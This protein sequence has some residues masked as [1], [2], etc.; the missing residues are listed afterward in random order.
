MKKCGCSST[1]WLHFK[2][3]WQLIMWLWLK[4]SNCSPQGF[5]GFKKNSKYLRFP[6]YRFSRTGVTHL[7]TH[8]HTYILTLPAATGGTDWGKSSPLSHLI[9]RPDNASLT[10]SST[11]K[12]RHGDSL[13]RGEI[14]IKPP[15]GRIHAET[16][17]YDGRLV[18][19]W[20]A[21]GGAIT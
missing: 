1:Y 10:A 12:W 19:K 3:H 4:P 17:H 5:S 2:Y 6:S 16:G 15:R 11:A 8:T 14:F 20:N 7:H 18:K 13:G 9:S 21:T